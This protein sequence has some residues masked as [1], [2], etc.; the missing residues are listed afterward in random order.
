MIKSKFNNYEVIIFT[1]CVQFVTYVSIM[2]Y[3]E[4]NDV[5]KSD[6]VCVLEQIKILL[7]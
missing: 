7:S 3:F 4:E 6:V 1:I 2:F 5:S